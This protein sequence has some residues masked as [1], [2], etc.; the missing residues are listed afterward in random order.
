M[1]LLQAP[2]RTR[3]APSP[4]GAPHIGTAYIA[5][6]NYAFARSLGGEFIL[7]IEDTDQV[8]ST[9][10]SEREIIAAL[11]WLGIEWD[12]GPDASGPYGPYRQSERV[13]LHRDRGWQL[14]H[15]GHAFPCFCTSQRLKEL[16]SQQVSCGASF[17]YDGA[18][19]G[20][21][22]EKANDRM[23]SG[24][25]YVIRMRVP[26]SGECTFVDRLRGEISIPWENVDEQVLLKSDGFPTYHLASVVDDHEM[27]ISHVIR[28]EEWISSTPKHVLLYEHFGWEPP[29]FVHLPLLRNPDKSKLSKRKNPTS[30]NYYRECGVLPETLVNYLCLMAYSLP[31]G[32]EVFPLGDFVATFDID[33][34]SL[35]GPVF[36]IQ[37][38]LS[39]NGTYLRQLSADGLLTRLREWKLNDDVLARIVPLVQPRMTRLGDFVPMSSFLLADQ[40]LY[41]CDALLALKLDPEEMLRVFTIARWEFEKATDWGSDAIRAVLSRIANM[42]NLKLRDMLPCFFVAVSGTTVSLPLFESLEILGRDMAVRRIQCALGCLEGEGIRISKKQLKKL[43]SY[44][45]AE[46]ST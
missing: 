7:R 27:G 43:E 6:F 40:I 9:R 31:D 20:L 26:T 41:E 1:A 35:G 5:L 34:I 29:E 2:V 39:M 45:R 8:R 13:Q 22:A 14:V 17:G 10:E 12:E 44:Y 3:L 42:E 16:R 30:V 36:D 11:D 25:P 19:A 4:T 46:Y 23:E 24:E 21:S 33:R 38:L 32:R 37:K 28:G 18:C 15:R